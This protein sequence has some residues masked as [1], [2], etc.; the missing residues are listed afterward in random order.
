MRLVTARAPPSGAPVAGSPWWRSCGDLLVG[1][2]RGGEHV[3]WVAPGPNSR[4]VV[5][6]RTMTSRSDS[7][8]ASL[9][10]E[11]ATSTAVPSSASG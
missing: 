4:V 6:A 10:S 7:R 11:V 2:R 5:P 1:A 9:R 8:S 3:G